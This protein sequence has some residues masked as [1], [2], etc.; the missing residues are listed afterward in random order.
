MSTDILMRRLLRASDLIWMK[1]NPW[2]SLLTC[3][4]LDLPHIRNWCHHPF[5]YSRL[6]PANHPRLSPPCLHPSHQVQLICLPRIAS[7]WPSHHPHS[8]YPGYVTRN[9]HW[10]QGSS[11]QGGPSATY[12]TLPSEARRMFSRQKF[13]DFVPYLNLSESAREQMRLL[14]LPDARYI[15]TKLDF[16]CFSNTQNSFPL[17]GLVQSYSLCLETDAPVISY[18][19]TTIPN[20][21]W[22]PWKDPRSCWMLWTTHICGRKSMLSVAGSPV[23]ASLK[24]PYLDIPMTSVSHNITVE[25]QKKVA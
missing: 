23:G 2:F 4:F 20:V 17:Q 25:F 6:T 12:N 7:L 16:F 19:R 13:S 24:C 15:L 22:S 8:D 10:H 18:Y 5:N 9:F 1:E 21:G 11:L 3:S 14:S